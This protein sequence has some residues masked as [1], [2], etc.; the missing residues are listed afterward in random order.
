MNENQFFGRSKLYAE[1][2][3]QLSHRELIEF[4]KQV[5]ALNERMDALFISHFC[6]SFRKHMGEIFAFLILHGDKLVKCYTKSDFE[7]ALDHKPEYFRK[8]QAYLRLTLKDP[9]PRNPQIDDIVFRT[10]AFS[11]CSAADLSG[12]LARYSEKSSGQRTAG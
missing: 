10:Y 12:F 1:I 9:A 7:R 6:I 2:I 5:C 4:S 11:N 3:D 8:K